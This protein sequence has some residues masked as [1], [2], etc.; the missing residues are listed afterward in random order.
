MK[1]VL[2]FVLVF[3]FVFQV[4]FPGAK[5]S[6][7]SVPSLNKFKGICVRADE[8]SKRGIDKSL[9][10]ISEYGYNSIFVLVKTPEGQVVF[11]S[12]N[13]PVLVDAFKEIIVSAK[14]Y[15]LKVYA[16]FPVMMDKN[17]AS[18]HPSEKMYNLGY[19]NNTYY[20]SLISKNFINY[21]KQF[22]SELLQYDIDGIVFDYIRYPNGSYDF[23]DAF[24][25]YGKSNGI[26]VDYVKSIAYKTFIKPADWKTMFVLYEQGDKDIVAWVNLREQ[27]LKNVVTELKNYILQRKPDLKLGAFLVSRGYRYDSVKDAPTIK[28]A[29][30]YQKVNFAYFGDTFSGILDFVIPMVYLSSLEE[31]PDYATVVANKI[32]ALTQGNLEFF[33]GINPDSISPSDAELEIY[34]AYLSSNGVVLFRHP[35]FTMGDIAIENIQEGKEVSYTVRNSLGEVKSGTFLFNDVFIPPAKN[36]IIVNHFYKFYTL[37]FTVGDKSYYVDNKINFMDVPPI[38]RDSRTFVPVRFLTEAL[39]FKVSYISK[40]REVIIGDNY[41]KLQIGNKTYKV[42]EN[43]FNMDVAPFIENS[44]TYVP[45]RFV[46][47]ALSFSVNWNDESKSITIQGIV[48]ID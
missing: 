29:Y 48:R 25:S 1:K 42:K 41:I 36:E 5:A 26:N 13:F 46:M 31:T 27:I 15:R 44:R 28:K 45:L 7:S 18:K 19:E 47:E 35:L 14:K 24:I 3:V 9:K 32:K 40:T 21:I 34:N 39:G 6:I 16:Y 17:Y 12:K 2:L 37:I 8:L 20:V 43:E 38:I 23:S 22:L 33:I 30:A 10:E 4:L 11:N